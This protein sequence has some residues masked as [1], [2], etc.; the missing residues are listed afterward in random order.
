M[1]NVPTF[2]CDSSPSFE[3]H[4]IPQKFCI[5]SYIAQILRFD[6]HKKVRKAPSPALCVCHILKVLEGSETL[7]GPN[8]NLKEGHQC[9]QATYIL[10]ASN[11]I[12]TKIEKYEDV[13]FSIFIAIQ[14]PNKTTIL[15]NITQLAVM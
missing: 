13:M 2:F 11:I 6:P 3:S 4:I 1:L 10:Y 15:C 9:F 8:K 5:D 12:M 14:K 7:H